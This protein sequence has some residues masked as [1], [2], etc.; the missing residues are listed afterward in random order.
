[1]ISQK[2]HNLFHLEYYDPDESYE[3]DVRAFIYALKE[4]MG[5]IEV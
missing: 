5:E 2:I 3:Q 4:K 1:M